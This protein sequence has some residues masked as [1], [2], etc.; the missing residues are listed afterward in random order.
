MPEALRQPIEPSTETWGLPACGLTSSLTTIKE[1]A[2]HN[3]PLLLRYRVKNVSQKNRVLWQSGFWP[4]HRLIA[5]DAE[6]LPLPLTQ[7]GREVR[8]AFAPNGSRR[9]TFAVS[10]LPGAIEDTFAIIDLREFFDV[11]RVRELHICCIYH[12]GSVKVS[13]NILVIYL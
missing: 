11:N 7:R 9:K 13:S 3:E 1:R 10:L 12:E 8:A 5:K 2:A 4:N 6:G